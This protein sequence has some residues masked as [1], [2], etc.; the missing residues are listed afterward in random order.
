ML[1]KVIMVKFSFSLMLFVVI[2]CF[3]APPNL[4]VGQLGFFC[5]TNEVHLKF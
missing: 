4:A 2:E 1:L 3:R 5:C